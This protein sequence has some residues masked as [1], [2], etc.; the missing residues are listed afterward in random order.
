MRPRGWHAAAL[1]AAAVPLAG[2]API[3]AGAARDGAP[4]SAA[5]HQGAPPDHLAAPAP[6]ARATPALPTVTAL[7]AGAPP[8]DAADTRTLG[9]KLYSVDQAAPSTLAFMILTVLGS[10]G[11]NAETILPLLTVMYFSGAFEGGDGAAAMRRTAA[12]LLST[13]SH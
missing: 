1:V 5:G 3:A 2:G 12:S 11:V 9:D 8:I 6:T 13:G 10:N 7:S 4:A